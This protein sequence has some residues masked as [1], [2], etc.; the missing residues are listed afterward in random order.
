MTHDYEGDRL[1]SEYLLLHYGETADSMPYAFGPVDALHFPKRCVE[2]LLQRERLSPQSTALDLGCAVG[3]SAFELAAHCIDV[4]GIDLSKRFIETARRLAE[5]GRFEYWFLEEGNIRTPHTFKI[6]SHCPRGRVQFRVGDAVNLPD[7]IGQYDVVMMANLICRTPDPTRC[8]KQGMTCVKPGGQLI[9]TTPY[10]WLDT[11]TAS[12][13]WLGGNAES[14]SRGWDAV[15]AVLSD[16]FELCQRRDMPFCI[17]EHARKFQWSVADA[18][19]WIRRN[20]QN[21]H[22]E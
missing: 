5:Q 9:L 4:T 2:E 1:L 12:D 19:V 8:L 16:D 15:A 6:P 18:S 21:A 7:D 14:Q 13:K 17:R 10:T 22:D 3:R 11:F 20:A